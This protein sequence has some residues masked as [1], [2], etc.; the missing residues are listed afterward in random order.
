[1]FGMKLGDV[2]SGGAAEFNKIFIYHEY[3]FI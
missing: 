1:M 3:T 2:D